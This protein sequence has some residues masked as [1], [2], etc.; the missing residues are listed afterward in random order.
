MSNLER[1]PVLERHWPPPTRRSYV[2]GELDK[3]HQS[4][5]QSIN[6]SHGFP[7]PNRSFVALG[8]KNRTGSSFSQ[9]R[10]VI[11]ESYGCSALCLTIYL[12]SIPSSA[13][14][15]DRARASR[16]SPFPCAEPHGRRSAC[17]LGRIVAEWGTLCGRSDLGEGKEKSTG[18]RG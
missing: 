8:K 6:R 1:G 5:N 4:I 18:G 17:L 7:N 13:C 9:T 3:Q 15:L 10:K 11:P 16:A 14:C 2:A 12:C